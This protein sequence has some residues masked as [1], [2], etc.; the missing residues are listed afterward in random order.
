MKTFTL[1]GLNK[2]GEEAR[3]IGITC[4]SVKTRLSEHRQQKTPDHRGRWILKMQQEGVVPEIVSFCVGLTHKEACELEVGV[5][6]ELRKQ[7]FDLVNT[8]PGGTAPMFGRTYKM[9]PETKRKI[10]IANTGKIHTVEA[11]KN[12]SLAH[13]GKGMGDANPF[14]GK[15]HTK[16]AN[17]KN[18]EAHRGNQYC[19]GF[20]HTEET[21]KNMSDSQ[22][23]NK[24]RLGKTH[25]EATKRQIS[26]TKTGAPV[27][28]ETR[29]ILSEA[30]KNSPATLEQCRKMGQNNVG[31]K[32]SPEHCDK[33][34]ASK[35]GKKFSKLSVALTGRKLSPEA[36]A[37]ISVALTGRKA[38]SVALSNS[39]RVVS[40]TTKGK[41]SAAQSLRWEK[42]RQE[43]ILDEM[44]Q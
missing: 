32:Y 42:K 26:A 8:S 6:A 7:G 15:S 39:E 18:A 17:E 37:K 35:R 2:P 11:R 10:G 27:S 24:K 28:I 16:E 4:K 36:C 21:R 44:W 29:K 9:P 43:E 33:I 30:A 40:D 1:Y 5:I 19:V 31:R 14:F 20:K 3:Y 12:M 23:G 41:M 38:P 22:K 34:S 25:S 13:Q